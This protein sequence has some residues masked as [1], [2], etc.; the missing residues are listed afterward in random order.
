MVYRSWR[1]QVLD[2][3]LHLEE[4]EKVLHFSDH[5]FSRQINLYTEYKDKFPNLYKERVAELY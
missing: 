5:I 1:Y 4:I 3:M 2:Q